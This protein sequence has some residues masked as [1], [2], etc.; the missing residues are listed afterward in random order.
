MTDQPP[1]PQRRLLTTKQAAEYLG[2]SQ[3]TLWTMTNAGVIPSVRFG[4]GR[5]Q[6]V[7]YDLDD[8]D[9]WI[10]SRKRGGAV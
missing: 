8:L 3:R 2:I 5:R 1:C 9:G 6:S 7:R 10:A 4:A